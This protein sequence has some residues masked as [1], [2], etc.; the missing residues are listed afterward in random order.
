[1]N[2]NVRCS[3]KFLC[4]EENLNKRGIK[5]QKIT[6]LVVDDSPLIIL[7]IT[8]LLEDVRNISLLRSCGTYKDALRL[9]SEI[10]PDVV[11]LDINLP[12]NS[13]IQLLSYIK[14]SFLNI[15]VIMCTN[16]AHDYYSQLCYTLGANYFVDKSKD[17]EKI[18]L[19]I[20]SLNP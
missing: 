20:S 15:V 5:K 9:L 18:P 14:D 17:F 16:H 6:L 13:G 8:E 2:E 12:D 19:L 1:M 7:K 4:S 11:L 3:A 10:Q